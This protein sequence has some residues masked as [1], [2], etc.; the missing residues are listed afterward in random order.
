MTVRCEPMNF[1]L[2]DHN[3]YAVTTCYLSSFDRIIK[4]LHVT[5][6]QPNRLYKVAVRYGYTTLDPFQYKHI[7]FLEWVY[8]YYRHHGTILNGALIEY[9]D[10]PVIIAENKNISWSDEVF[11]T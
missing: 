4:G 7:Y 11:I 5:G 10:N 6:K 9:F 8:H 3:V 2:V 1:Y